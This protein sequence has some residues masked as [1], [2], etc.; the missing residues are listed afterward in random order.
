MHY[1]VGGNNEY[2]VVAICNM[3]DSGELVV[4]R[5]GVWAMM[6]AWADGFR[7]AHAAP[8]IVR[9]CVMKSTCCTDL[10]CLRP[11]LAVGSAACRR[12]SSPIGAPLPASDAGDAP[13]RDPQGLV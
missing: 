11:P 3:G 9:G 5:C 4:L 7:P 12:A 8:K 6:R 2:G 13:S 1:N 10:C